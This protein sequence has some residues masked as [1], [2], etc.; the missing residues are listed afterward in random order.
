MRGEFR[1]L[2]MNA[3]QLLGLPETPVVSEEALRDAFREAGKKA[4]PDAGGREE[5]FAAVREAHGILASPSRRVRHWLELRGV[6]VEARGAIGEGLMDL[7]SG[8][9][10]VSQRAEGVIRKREAARSSLS[11]AL[12]EGEAQRCREEV[13]AGISALDAEIGERCGRI[14]AAGEADGEGLAR[15]ARDLA[16]LEKWRQG[17]RACYA[18]LV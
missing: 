9:G 14:A 18:R 12:L 4:H 1:G 15:L 11:R 3:F 10:A 13:E 8:I 7:F 5:D 16:F 2:M 17:L 6:E